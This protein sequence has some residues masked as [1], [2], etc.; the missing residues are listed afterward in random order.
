M[1]NKGYV[2]TAGGF[3][4]AISSVAVTNETNTKQDAVTSTNAATES[5]T[6]LTH[7]AATRSIKKSA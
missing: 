3:C 6:P 4:V 7:S 2:A 1:S 5:Q